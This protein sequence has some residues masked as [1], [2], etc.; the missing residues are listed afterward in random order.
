MEHPASR[1]REPIVTDAEIERAAQK[2]GYRVREAGRD[3]FFLD[4]I[5]PESAPTARS[6]VD[7]AFTRA[8]LVEFLN[9]G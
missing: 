8:E 1:T 3:Q 4:P 2:I 6:L 9:R 7:R 5:K